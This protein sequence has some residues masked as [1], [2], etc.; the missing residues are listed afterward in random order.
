M[1]N[2]CDNRLRVSGPTEA[3]RQFID[4]ATAIDG[5]ITLLHSYIPFPPGLEGERITGKDG[6]PVGR[7]FTDR[8]Y[9]W[10][11]VNWGCKWGDDGTRVISAN[12]IQDGDSTIEMY[13][14]TP[15]GPPTQG[16][17]LISLIFRELTFTLAFH[18]DEMGFAGGHQISA[19]QVISDTDADCPSWPENDDDQTWIDDIE[20]MYSGIFTTLAQ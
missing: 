17:Q 7:A 16:I 8:G 14:T 10:C 11:L 12:T 4:G 6:E 18:E 19:G 15:W 20:E 5:K 1:P 2:W 9:Q 3:V 13:F